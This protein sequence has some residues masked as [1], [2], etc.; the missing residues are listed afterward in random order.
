MNIYCNTNKPTD[1]WIH[2]CFN[3]GANTSYTRNYR[4]DKQTHVVFLCRSCER[5]TKNEAAEQKL[6]T[7]FQTKIK[8][9]QLF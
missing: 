1:G 9:K 5:K 6:S 2:G 4:Y 3:C 7:T 8:K